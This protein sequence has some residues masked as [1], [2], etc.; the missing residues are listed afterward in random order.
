MFAHS[1]RWRFQLWLAL[2]L[3]CVLT[4]FG[5][6][7]YELQRR[8]LYSR[9]ADE[10]SHRISV[11]S[12]AVRPGP[13]PGHGPGPPRF[14]FNGGDGNSPPDSGDF[15]GRPGSDR[16]EPS[17]GGDRRM[18]FPAREINLSAQS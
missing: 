6:A 9:T 4:G 16:R 2:L 15:P 1:I 7:V 11:L 18:S 5:A 10:I 13:P 14:Q 12:S 17:F 8:N 3:A